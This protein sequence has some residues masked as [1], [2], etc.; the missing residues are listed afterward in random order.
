MKILLTGGAGF[1]GSHTAISLIEAGHDVVIVDNF[2]NSAPSIIDRLT[3]LAQRSI[4][5]VEADVRDEG[6]MVQ[7][8][9]S[10]NIDAVVHFAG[11]KAVAESMAKPLDYF[12][13]NVGGLIRTLFA[14]DRVGVDRLVFSSS[15]TVYGENVKLPAHEEAPRS[16]VNPY[17]RT[18]LICEQIL[19]DLVAS[20]DKWR[21]A[22]LRY[23]NPVGAHPSG[24]IGENPVGTPNNLMPLLLRAASKQSGPL[25]VF[26]TDYPTPDGTAVRDYL[27]VMD[28]AEGHVAALEMLDKRNGLQA[29]NLGT[30]TGTSVL[31]IIRRFA[32]VTGV[33]VPHEMAGRRDGDVAALY[34]SADRARREIG[35]TAIRDLD[36]MCR[37]SWRAYRRNR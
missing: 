14:M 34:A 9:S 26:G 4:D 21:V 31:E 33:D 16:T 2:A 8:L 13:N 27:H 19:E 3:D 32:E 24:T 7:T 28:L 18:K 6:K 1:I 35:W 25:K 29:Y 12:D 17:G 20:D 11:H 23:F 37:D 10:Y 22:T 15:A 30:G 5:I 36:D